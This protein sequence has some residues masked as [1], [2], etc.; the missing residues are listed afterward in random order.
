MDLEI[1]LGAATDID[2]VAP[3]WM[4]M[5]EHHREL[6]G[7]QWPVRPAEHAWTLRREQYRSWLADGS[8][9]LFVARIGESV[10]LAGY[11]FCRL[12]TSGPTF[13]LGGAHGEVES[14]VVAAESRGTGVGTA[15]LEAFR[16]ELRRRAITYWSIGFVEAN[17]GAAALYERLG[18]RPWFRTMLA[19]VDAPEDRQQ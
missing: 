9:L 8:G 17:D 19:P 16:T 13:D 4:A 5:V 3:L 2:G 11:A 6:V 1:G 7:E 15:L 12:A 14:L 18:F 10:A